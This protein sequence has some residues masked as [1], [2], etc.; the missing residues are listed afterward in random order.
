MGQGS[1]QND[2]PPPVAVDW[3]GPMKKHTLTDW[4]CL[5]LFLAFLGGWGF[6]AYVAF[7][8]GDISKVKKTE[9]Y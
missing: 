2:P 4:P 9:S 5:L 3:N 1:S 8:N 7:T 6:V